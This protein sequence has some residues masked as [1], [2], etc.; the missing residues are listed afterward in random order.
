MKPSAVLSI[1][2]SSCLVTRFV[3]FRQ[4]F[5]ELS[6]VFVCFF[7]TLAKYCIHFNH[8]KCNT[9]I[10]KVEAIVFCLITKQKRDFIEYWLFSK[11]ILEP[12]E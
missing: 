9:N 7:S 12:F 1:Y 4:S 3:S 5:K 8:I 6:A 10:S 11:N 2:L